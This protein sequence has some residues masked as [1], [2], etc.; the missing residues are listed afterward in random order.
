VTGTALDSEYLMIDG[1]IIRVH[2]Q[3]TGAT[4]GTHRQPIGRSRGG[5]TTKIVALVDA[6]GNLACFILLPGQRH[7]LVGVAPLIENVEFDMFL[8]DKAFDA[9]W[10]RTELNQRGAIVVIP[11]KSN[12]AQQISCDF[13]AYHWRHLVENFFC[14]LI[15]LR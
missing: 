1:T 10:L 14:S 13:H 6:L 4:G 9:D 3:G 2:Q 15:L 12:R 8:A 11:P 5:L 7:D